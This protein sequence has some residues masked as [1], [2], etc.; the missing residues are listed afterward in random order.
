MQNLIDITHT[1]KSADRPTPDAK[2]LRD[3][4][5]GETVWYTSAP[6][7]AEPGQEPEDVPPKSA[8]RASKKGEGD[9]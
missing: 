2:L 9:A 4:I 3:L 6:S 5:T 1:T 8:R 7:D